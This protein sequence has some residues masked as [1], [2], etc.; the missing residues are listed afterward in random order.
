[1]MR[2]IL[3]LILALAVVSSVSAAAF[4]ATAGENTEWQNYNQVVTPI[5]SDSLIDADDTIAVCTKTTFQSGWIYL[6][7]YGTMTGT[8]ADS[9][10]I[11][12]AVKTYD[13]NDSLLSTTAVET[14]TAV[15]SRNVALPIQRTDFGTKFTILMSSSAAHGHQVLIPTISVDRVRYVDYTKVVK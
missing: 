14:I 3:G 7:K 15:T 6:L 5:A 1:M 8:G 11:D 10:D 13:R 12:I 2:K 9:V 4:T